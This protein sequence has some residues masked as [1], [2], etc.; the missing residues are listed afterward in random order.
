MKTKL[1]FFVFALLSL[2]SC[3]QIID[4]YWDRKEEE[5]MCRPFKARTKEVIQATK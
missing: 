4:N 1:T 5:T 3:E 2:V